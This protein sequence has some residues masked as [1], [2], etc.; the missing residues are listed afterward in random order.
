MFSAFSFGK[1]IKTILPG[2]ILTLGFLM[3]IE[4]FWALWGAEAGFLLGKVPKDW[5][6]PASAGLIPLALI[7]GF[8][9]NTFAWMVLNR[10][11]RKQR[12]TQ[13]RN[14]VFADLREKL[15][16]CLWNDAI[17]YFEKA[18]HELGIQ[19]PIEPALEYYYLPTITLSNLNYLWESYFCWYEFAINSACAILLS[20]VPAILL[21]GLRFRHYHF[22]P[23]SITLLIFRTAL[24][25]MLIRAAIKN[26]ASYEKNL[27]LLI[28]GSLKKSATAQSSEAVADGDTI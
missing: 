15:S 13:L 5:V 10:K 3:L 23:F 4:D 9:L 7:L 24:C 11:M 14:T 12:D 8:F 2:S 18:G 6:T 1:I 26:L 19:G 27:L 16:A 21:L 28:T 20:L 25:S 22:L 17:G